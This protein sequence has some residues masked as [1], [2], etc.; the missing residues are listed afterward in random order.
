ML[1]ATL[2]ACATLILVL[3]V[4]RAGR[5]PSPGTLLSAQQEWAGLMDRHEE[6]KRDVTEWH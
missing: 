2:A 3:A 4:P 5:G 6:G 1:Y